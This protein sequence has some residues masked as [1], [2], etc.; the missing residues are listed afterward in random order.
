MPGIFGFVCTYARPR[1]EMQRDLETMRRSMAHL[2]TYGFH[3][4]VGDRVALGRVGP[5]FLNPEKQPIFSEDRSRM[6]VFE[7]ELFD[8]SGPRRRL[9]QA[10]HVFRTGCDAEVALHAFEES[11]VRGIAELAGAYVGC[12]YDSTPG[13]CHLF[14]DR[15]GLRGCYY[16]LTPDV[17]FVFASEMKAIVALPCFSGQIDM[18]GV[19]A[20]LNVGY[21]FFE[22]TFFEEVKYMP[23]G[24]VVSFEC[25]H[26]KVEQYWDMPRLEAPTSWRFEDAVEEGGA[27]LLQ[28]IRR[29]LRQG[30]RIGA[31]LSGGLDSR[32]IVGSA[33]TLGHRVPTFTLGD[34]VNTELRLATRVARRMRLEHEAL[35]LRSDFLVDHGEWGDWCTDG[36][37]PCT[38]LVWLSRLP[39]VASRV[40]C[41]FSGYLG[42]VFLGGVFLRG[43]REIDPP[44]RTQ[45]Q[46]IATRFAGTFSPLLRIG[47]SPQFCHSLE[48]AHGRASEQ[49]AERVG[50]R[51]LGL[52]MDR[53]SLAT[54]E[55]RMTA[56]T[57]GAVINFFVDVKYPFGDYDLL[58]FVARLPTE[59]RLGSHL[60]KAILCRALP[61]LVDIPC[62]SANTHYVQC[63]LDSDPSLWRIMW[64]KAKAQWRYLLVRLS[65]GRLSIPNLDTYAHPDHWYQ[66]C[67]AL[68]RWLETTL[69]DDRTLER[70]YYNREGIKRLLRLETKEGWL[71][72]MLANL[73]TFEHW[74][75]FFIDGQPPSRSGGAPLSPGA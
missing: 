26:V 27:L 75:R 44:I 3:T 29:Q 55:R 59:W 49:I 2:P 67:P 5:S 39:D 20:F 72:W 15:L 30:G 23:Y 74:N 42:G 21:P 24:S 73:V 13:A 58:D 54:D 17:T 8:A 32:A 40:Q 33:A 57:N 34:G 12:L 18:Q 51:G 11:R 64:R 66:T 46:L 63:T 65:G 7:G 48:V 25:G 52:E 37:V 61:G 31:F 45:R 1:E 69:L 38:Q 47:L 9:E 28:A 68:R 70:G 71:F 62:I 10:G 22:R 36:M 19:A 35:A 56:F 41:L 50:A 53:A 43:L 60:Y 6:V 14:T 4:Y 16:C